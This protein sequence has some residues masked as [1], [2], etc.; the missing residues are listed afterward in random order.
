MND[1]VKELAR[2]AHEDSL[3]EYRFRMESEL[4][5]DV[6]FADIYDRKFA[7]LIVL[8]C[9]SLLDAYGMPDGTSPVAELL[10]KVIK[11]K[12]GVE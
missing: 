10:S 1:K 11:R 8:E 6:I 3:K 12:F 9:L 5:A 7:E 4:A 2:L